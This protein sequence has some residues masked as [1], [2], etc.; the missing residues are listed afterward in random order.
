M[1]VDERK[2]ETIPPWKEA[3]VEGLVAMLERYDSVGVVD[4][5]GIP[6]RQLQQMRADLH[7][8]AEIRMSRNTL[9]ERALE[10]VDEGLEELVSSVSGHVGLVGT[11]DNPF[12]LFQ[13]LEASKTPAPIS[14]GETAPNDIVIS[15]GDTGMDPGPFVGELQ[16]VGAAAQIMEGS[17]K[18][19]EDSVVAEA[20][21]VIPEDLAAVLDELGIEPKEV[22]LDL[23]AVVADGVLFDAADLDIDLDAYEADLKAAAARG[24][25]LSIN[26]AYPTERTVGALLTRASGEAK[27][28]GLQAEIE[29]PEVLPDLVG[30]ADAQVHALATRID[31]E[32]ALPEGLRDVEAPA[33]EPADANDSGETGEDDEPTDDQTADAD[34]AAD[35]ED[36]GDDDGDGADAL[37]DMFG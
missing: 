28:V 16:T 34:E 18:V 9:I 17:I 10:R 30:R 24:Q 33:A 31:D 15:E 26:A 6:S 32:E 3:E 29:S 2:T 36:D 19:T 7:G 14:A 11:D 4:V 8:T 35:E 22:G 37:G 21:D 25:N 5:E 12:G 23:R 27:S 13:Q 20:G 1:S